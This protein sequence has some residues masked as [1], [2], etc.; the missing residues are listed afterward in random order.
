MSL[1]KGL[2]DDI[3]AKELEQCAL[4]RGHKKGPNPGARGEIYVKDMTPA[5]IRMTVPALVKALSIHFD[6][7]AIRPIPKGQIVPKERLIHSRM[8]IVNK[9][10]LQELFEPKGRLCVGG[11]RD[12]DLGKYESSSPTALMVAHMVLLAVATIMGWPVDIGDVT[13]AFL[14]GLSLPRDDP[15]YIRAP[16][17]VPQGGVGVLGLAPRI[18]KSC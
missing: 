10:W 7:D 16:S 11:H 14:Q 17:G 1:E 15:I 2:D 8:V 12:P 9:K 6:H 13:A 18:F 5:E 4:E 3:K